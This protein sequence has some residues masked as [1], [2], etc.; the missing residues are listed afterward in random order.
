[1]R[2]LKVLTIATALATAAVGS[3]AAQ[4]QPSDTGTDANGPI[5]ILKNMVAEP[6][7]VRVAIDGREV[8]HLQ[9]ATYA[10][11]TASVHPGQNTMTVSWNGPVPQL[12][13]KIAYAPTRN[14]FKNVIV[15]QSDQSRD[16]SLRQ[17]G[18]KSYS[19]NIPGGQ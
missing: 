17:A 3:A 13:F 18:S 7:G 4:Q 16:A 5:T 8:D 9:A 2:T 11:I 6:A 1:M 10:D 12:N 19:F 15:V 14:N